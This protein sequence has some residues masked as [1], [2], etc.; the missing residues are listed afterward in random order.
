MNLEIEERIEKLEAENARLRRLIAPYAWRAPWL[1]EFYV[2]KREDNGKAK[3][4]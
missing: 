2:P 3:G 4:E 1:Y